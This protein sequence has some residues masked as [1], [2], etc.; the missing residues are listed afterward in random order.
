MGTSGTPYSVSCQWYFFK[1][2]EGKDPP[3]YREKIELEADYVATG[4]L[5]VR[6][7]KPLFGAGKAVV[8]DSGFVF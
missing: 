4:G 8:M 7:R 3:K 5:M 6:V 2:V 1:L